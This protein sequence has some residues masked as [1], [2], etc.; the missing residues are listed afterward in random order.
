MLG[1]TADEPRPVEEW[2]RVRLAGGGVRHG[3]GPGMD[4]TDVLIAIGEAAA[5]ADKGVVIAEL[6]GDAKSYAERL[7][8]FPKIRDSTSPGPAS[9]P[10][11]VGEDGAPWPVDS[12]RRPCVQHRVLVHATL[13]QPS[14][15]HPTR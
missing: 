10:P 1:R 9:T 11:Q 13:T 12:A 3:Q 15:A 7:F 14:G 5:E 8:K 2:Q 6:A 4:L